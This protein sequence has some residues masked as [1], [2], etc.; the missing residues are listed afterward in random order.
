LALGCALIL[1]SPTL[2]A[3]PP[4][5]PNLILI[6]ADDL[7]Y[8]DLGC[9]GSKKNRTPNLDRMARQGIRLTSFYAIANV[10]TP[11][12][13]S[14]LTGCY[15][16]RVGLHQN[17]KG[18]GV[19]FPANTRG[20]SAAEITLAAILRALGYA[21][22]CIGKW[23]LGDQ[24]PFLPTRHGFDHYFGIPYSNDMGRT[25]RPKGKE[26]VYPPLPLLRDEKVIETEPD[27]SLLTARYTEEAIRFITQNKDRPFFLY[28]AHTMPHDPLFASAKFR[29]KSA[30][31]KLGDAVEELDWSVGRIL[32]TLKTLG[33]DDNTLV[34]FTSD[35]GGPPRP[36][37]SNA[38]L[39]GSK[40]TTWEGGH[41]VPF[42]A[43]WP[44]HVPAGKES[45]EI[46]VSFDLLPTF[47][48]LAG[49]KAPAGRII[50]GKDIWP[51]LASRPGARS[52]HEA[53]FFYAG[54]RLE[55]V[56][57]GKWKLYLPGRNLGPKK[58]GKKGP[59]PL[60]LYDL[61]KDLGEKTDVAAQHPEVVKRL[62]ALAERCR[63]DLGDG[64]RP[65]K[66][67][68]PPGHVDNAKPLTRTDAR[69]PIS[70]S[71]HWAPMERSTLMRPAVAIAETWRGGFRW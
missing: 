36:A 69:L 28:L 40:A 26:K 35:N 41:R 39:R 3:G 52:P 59:T 64:K 17:E 68:R 18:Q 20:L 11:T 46:A 14:I 51:L 60:Q 2:A 50:D 9:F 57:S 29:G 55:G 10:C 22:F 5:K 12:R 37:T 33:L 48:K 45:G 27:Q 7:G 24:L 61:E 1:A 54:A 6:L 44:G 53:I 16:Q 65:G 19:L 4:K 34:C 71:G 56:R 15:P 63:E 43:R 13:A 49:G 30:N 62:Q 47:A 23:H 67:T 32:E 25:A 42:I 21:T 31:G 8:A 58:K 38:P 70:P 66:N